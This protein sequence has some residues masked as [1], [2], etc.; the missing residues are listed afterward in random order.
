MTSEFTAPDPAAAEPPGLDAGA[1]PPRPEAPPPAPEATAPRDEPAPWWRVVLL[2]LAT[3]ATSIA[4]SFTIA[5]LT[6]A[7]AVLV[8]HRFSPG[9]LS[10]RRLMGH[11]LFMVLVTWLIPLCGIAI[12]LAFLGRDRSGRRAR[13][14]LRRGLLPAGEYVT[15]VVASFILLFAGTA[16]ARALTDLHLLPAIGRSRLLTNL[17]FGQGSAG[18]RVAMVIAGSLLTGIYEEMLTRGYLQIGLLRR[19]PPRLAL[20]VTALLFAAGHGDFTY[21]LGVLPFGLWLSWL[22]WRARTIL[23]GMLSHVV[24]NGTSMTML[25]TVGAGT[26]RRALESRPTLPTATIVIGGII[27]LVV[28]GGIAAWC[29]RRI[30]R[31]VREAEAPR[32]AVGWMTPGAPPA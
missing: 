13:L 21:A 30:E 6:S 28:F 3:F 4:A 22:A 7:V 16:T 26:V 32:R 12:V 24:V 10:I 15:A 20:P 5:L 18:E 14:G 1:T 2:A 8:S 29:V 9:A 11:P 27:D 23:P 31:R 17:Q 19:W 25:A